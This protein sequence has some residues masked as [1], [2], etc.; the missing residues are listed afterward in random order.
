MA[1]DKILLIGN[2]AREHVIAET[3]AKSEKKPKIFSFMK[4][5]NPGIISFSVK[6]MNGNYSDLDAI[7]NF[8]KENNID[9]AFIG[10]E[11]PLS[12]GV[13]DSL[14][15]IGI[16]SVGPKKILAQLETSKS[17]TRELL[18]KHKIDGSPKFQVCKSRHDAERFIGELDESEQFV[19]KPDGLTGG[20]GVWVQGE[21]FQEKKEGLRYAEEVFR[22]HKSVVIEE[23]LEGEEFSLMSFADGKNLFDFP[24]VQ[25]H[26]RAFENDTGPNTGGMGSY[27][28]DNHLLPF[29]TRKD[30]DD[31]H[32]ITRQVLHAISKETGE[33]YKGVMYGGFMLTRNGVKLIEY[34]ARLGDPEAMNVL[35]IL[36]NDLVELS[37]QVIEGKLNHAKPDFKQLSTVCKYAVPKGYP[38]NPVK[39]Q[40]IEIGYH[41]EYASLYYAAVDKKPDGLYMT[42]SRAVAFVGIAQNIE[43]AERI[44]EE[45]VSEVRGNVFHRRDI[46]TNALLM[47]RIEHMRK[48]RIEE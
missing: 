15:K 46:G 41:P 10:P 20:K 4:S 40:K 35:P 42:G 11:E 25:D 1:M 7:N 36:N 18:S 12:N 28:L 8:A 2:G 47:K 29:L 39:N 48:I 38:E 19:V 26:K 45:C 31:A 22:H 3:L 5:N 30:I 14:H 6:S 44:A 34:N 24:P 32:E 37:Y 23:K 33:P 27:S 43:D 9:F 17:F 16:P 13:A 21:H